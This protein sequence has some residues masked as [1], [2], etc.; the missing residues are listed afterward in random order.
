MFLY[1][2]P[3]PIHKSVQKKDL[4]SWSFLSISSKALL[5]LSFQMVHIRQ[6]GPAL[7]AL[8]FLAHKGSMP[9]QEVSFHK[10]VH[11]PLHPKKGED[12]KSKHSGL[13]AKQKKVICVFLLI[14]TQKAPVGDALTKSLQA[15]HGEQPA[16]SRLP[17]RHI[18]LTFLL[19]YVIKM[20]VFKTCFL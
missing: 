9:T 13:L 8:S 4:I 12:Q 18:L 15:V 3:N 19:Q 14:F 6:R 11:Y 20:H 16:P 10:R 7:Q 17:T 5:F 1:I 2:H